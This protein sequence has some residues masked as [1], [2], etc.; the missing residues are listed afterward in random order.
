MAGMQEYLP[1]LIA[2]LLIHNSQVENELPHTSN[3]FLIID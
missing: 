1:I 3:P 2:H